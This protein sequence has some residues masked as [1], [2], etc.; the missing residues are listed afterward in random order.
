MV[1]SLSI[2]GEDEIAIEAGK[3]FSSWTEHNKKKSNRPSLEVRCDLRTQKIRDSARNMLKSALQSTLKSAALSTT[4][5]ICTSDKKIL[6]KISDDMLGEVG[7]VVSATSLGYS[8]GLRIDLDG[9]DRV[10]KSLD[11]KK[12]S[13]PTKNIEHQRK[14][15]ESH[16]DRRDKSRKSCESK[17]EKNSSHSNHKDKKHH[18][19][20]SD[21]RKDRSSERH[22]KK[23]KSSLDAS[24][25]E[26]KLG[27]CSSDTSTGPCDCIKN[28]VLSTSKPLAKA[29][30]K[31]KKPF[32]SSSE[33]CKAK[34]KILDIEYKKSKKAKFYHSSS[35]E[36]SLGE[37]IDSGVVI[38]SNSDLTV[39]KSEEKAS[40]GEGI[41]ADDSFPKSQTKK[42]KTKNNSKNKSSC[43][44]DQ[45]N[46]SNE[47]ISIDSKSNIDG[48]DSISQNTDKNSESNV[49]K[50]SSREDGCRKRHKSKRKHSRER[51]KS[52][53][54]T[55]S[56][57]GKDR[58][59]DKINK[60]NIKECDEKTNKKSESIDEKT[61]KKSESLDEKTNN[62]ESIHKITNIEDVV[63]PISDVLEQKLFYSNKRL[64]NSVYKK[65]MRKIIFAV[66][67][68]ESVRNQVLSSPDSLDA[69]VSKYIE[70]V[71]QSSKVSQ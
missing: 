35:N 55:K 41:S 53:S 26:E 48:D 63:A 16:S 38:S 12:N 10:L 51:K 23:D 47:K 3:V 70:E 54:D 28:L 30:D 49:I 4:L 1:E 31:E 21:E 57:E 58:H 50:R 45:N 52:S 2:N 61:N 13:S 43:D 5:N 46:L 33:T 7:D 17:R 15:G 62:K 20:S 66:K 71:S 18:K 69:F 22:A 19:R 11:K 40:N 34:R 44:A 59:K 27:F 14:N 37:S 36:K 68:Q 32:K 25:T 24:A 56:D 67:H 6:G 65:A 8:K 9:Y 42:P 29:Q 64:I 39:E 60:E